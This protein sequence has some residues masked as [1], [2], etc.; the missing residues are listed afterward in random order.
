MITGTRIE[1]RNKE[2]LDRMH[3]AIKQGGL[4]A[5][6]EFFAE[7]SYNH[8]FATSR[9]DIWAVLDDIENTFPDVNFEAHQ[10]VAEG[11]LVMVRYTMSGTHMGVQKLPFVHGGVLAGVQPTGKRINVK[12]IHI[13]RF[14]DSQVIEHDAVQDNL[15]MARQLGVSL[16]VTAPPR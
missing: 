4:T 12:H 15:E 16:E 1:G 11:D 10:I 8:G 7:Q 5:Q 14:K 13:F 6:V 3:Q 9:A 2:V